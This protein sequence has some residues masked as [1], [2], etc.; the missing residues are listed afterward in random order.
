MS[1]T[2]TQTPKTQT[3]RFTRGVCYRGTDYGPEHLD[4]PITMP[5]WEA[6]GFLSR[7]AAVIYVPPPPV[8]TETEPETGAGADGEQVADQGS[9]G[10]GT[11]ATGDTP[12]APAGAPS[13]RGKKK[14]K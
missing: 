8:E 11:A 5:G 4:E 12:S 14:G 7:G 10:A 2:S 1:L 9:D 13:G 6:A 3:I